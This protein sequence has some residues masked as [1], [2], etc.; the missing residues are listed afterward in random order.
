MVS[1]KTGLWYDYS[2]PSV[3]D[4]TITL[5]IEYGT[6]LL[7]TLTVMVGF[8][9]ASCWNILAFI[10]HSR[11]ITETS[12]LAIELQ[13]QVSLRNTSGSAGAMWQA[14]KLHRAWKGR[15]SKLWR[16]TLGF[17][18]PAAIVWAGS[19]AAGILTSRV[20]NKSYSNT[21]ARVKSDLCGTFYFDPN[22][23]QAQSAYNAKATHDTVEAR[24][25]MTK[26]YS[27]NSS[28]ATAR[29]LFVR[30]T[31]PYSVDN[32]A[33]CPIPDTSRCILGNTGGF[34][35]FTDALDS[36]EM[37]GI[38]AK[39][40]NRVTVQINVTCSPI[41][42][43]GLTGT[44][45]DGIHS[46][47]YYYLGSFPGDRNYT[48]AYDLLTAK[49]DVPYLLMP[50]L[51]LNGSWVPSP[52]FNRAD[53]D[54]SVYFLSQNSIIYMEPVND[55]WFLA[56]GKYQ[57]TLGKMQVN[58]P[59]HYVNTMVC[60]DQ[61]VYCNP[62]T[63]VCT[64]PAGINAAS[65]H[66]S[67]L[68]TPG[69]NPTQKITAGRINAA[70][71]NSN[72]YNSVL[73]L[74]AS[75]PFANSILVNVIS[76]GLPDDQWRTEALGW[77]QTSLAKLQAYM[78]EYAFKDA[79]SLGPYAIVTSPRNLNATNSEEAAENSAALDQCKNQLVQVA[80]EVQNF[81]FLGVMIIA[82]V[83]VFLVL[84]DWTLESIVDMVNRH[85]RQKNLEG[86]AARQADNSWHL[87]RM[88][89]GKPSGKDSGNEDGHAEAWM[90]GRW[91]VPVLSL[92]SEKFERPL[93]MHT[94]QRLVQYLSDTFVENRNGSQNDNSH[95]S[96]SQEA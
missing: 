47:R 48:Y 58:R 53:A 40:H 37:L 15:V 26:F 13:Q 90:M 51:A 94:Q 86:T 10:L 25:Y 80:A 70:L 24:T 22:S 7:S 67:D 30:P 96:N 81:S 56:T 34:A 75:A 20:A 79:R 55:P 73:N 95:S 38:N 68:N 19:T 50:V 87:L 65:S 21:V 91:G 39:P 84:L 35:M 64:P 76:T 66:I 28:P 49:M 1:V 5:P 16:R 29:S 72:T 83:T 46:Y 23:P 27:N 8:A 14:F 32:H 17:F 4:A 3:L 42:T 9:G 78:I 12:A 57:T 54:V 18:L 71:V 82:G 2:E 41:D 43:T 92:G 85:F 33:P 88:A 11:R 52:S 44:I 74:G 69:F 6:L 62:T 45:K 61:F 77:F 60:T 63:D 59:D 93:P 31:L 89:I 36:H